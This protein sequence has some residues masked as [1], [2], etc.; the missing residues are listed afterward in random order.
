MGDRYLL[1]LSFSETPFCG[2]G[3]QAV[4]TLRSMSVTLV[5]G[6]VFSLRCLCSAAGCLLQS[7]RAPWWRFS[8]SL[9]QPHR[10]HLLVVRVRLL[11]SRLR[12]PVIPPVRV[13]E[14]VQ[15]TRFSSVLRWRLL[16]Q[17]TSQ[18]IALSR[19]RFCTASMTRKGRAG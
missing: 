18:G 4:Q 11:I 7:C 10:M 16:P 2:I 5:A 15:S 19:V 13:A 9:T 8:V 12:Y 14:W 1:G 6:S 17:A 3:F